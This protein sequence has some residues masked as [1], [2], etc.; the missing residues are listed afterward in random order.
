MRPPGSSGISIGVS[1]ST[2]PWRSIARRMAELTVARTRRLRCMRVA[3]QVEVAVPQADALVDVVGAGVERE[4]RRLGRGED[5]DLA[6]AD[7][8]LAGGRLGLTVPSGRAPHGAGDPHH[9]LGCEV[10]CAVDDALHDAGVVAQVDEGEVLAVLAPAGRPSRTR[11]TS[12]TDVGGR[13]ARR[14]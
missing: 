3:A 1:T 7:L 11:A 10:G 14:T 6:V 9:V 8:D 12:A 4:R 2:K 5:L 13:A